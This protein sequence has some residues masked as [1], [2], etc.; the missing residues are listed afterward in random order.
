LI[1]DPPAHLP[2]QGRLGYTLVPFWAELHRS[3]AVAD[4]LPRPMVTRSK[5]SPPAGP[6]LHSLLNQANRQATTELRRR[7]G[8][9]GIPAEFWRALEVLVDERGRSMSELAELTGMQLPAMSKLVD[10]MTEAALVQRSADPL[11]QR[12]VIL[13]ISDFGLQK[14]AALQDEMRE[15]RDRLDRTFGPERQ[16][17]LREL[18]DAFIQAHR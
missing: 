12:R 16:A 3:R 4:P 1:I 17:Q 14:V 13:H 6:T 5:T 9:E 2:S 11:D 10:R 7:V 8:A 15:H 18:L